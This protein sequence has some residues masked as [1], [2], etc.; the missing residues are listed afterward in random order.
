MMSFFMIAFR[1]YDSET[2]HS[3][4]KRI[5]DNDQEMTRWLHQQLDAAGIPEGLFR[6]A[7]LRDIIEDEEI[8]IDFKKRI[9][10]NL[11]LD[12]IPPE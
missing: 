5:I 4:Y 9:S 10:W 8:L 2:K 11:G 6:S 1:E 3:V 12:Y 7:Y